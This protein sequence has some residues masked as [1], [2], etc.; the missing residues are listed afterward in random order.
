MP[1][2]S[3]R[4]T[5]IRQWE[6]LK[7]LPKRGAG[8]TARDLALLLNEAGFKVGKRQIERDLTT[9]SGAFPLAC[10]D[11]SI[12]YGWKWM[13]GRSVELPGM[14]VAEALS[15]KLVEDTLQPLLPKSVL[16]SLE[17]NFNQA[18]QKLASLDAENPNAQWASKVRNV[19]ATLPLLA[20]QV[21]PVVLEIAQEAL[22]LNKQLE[23]D[24]QSM[25]D[26]TPVARILNPL[27]LVNRGPVTYLVASRRDKADIHLYAMHR[28][29][30]A[31]QLNVDV[32]R[33][34]NFNLDDFINSGALQF[35]NG[36][37]IR[38]KAYIADWL[39]KY[40]TETPLSSDQKLVN[41]GDKIKLTATVSDSWQLNWWIFSQ[42][43]G[44]EVLAPM[45]LRK[46]IAEKLQQ[47][48]A[49]YTEPEQI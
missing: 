14:T 20:P 35:G 23:A 44:M 28:F 41:E 11:N 32:I 17:G 3:T 38:L 13:E 16:A 25:N 43:A 49:I 31:I 7:L 37:S 10:N 27:G 24:Y 5:L 40:L 26:S 45:A 42:G 4:N 6:L 8:K 36:K 19:Q 34:D 47:A 33:P 22:L 39:A 1:S 9:L 12:P 48:A 21:D 29:S 15:M 18:Q 30:R 46:S 2:D